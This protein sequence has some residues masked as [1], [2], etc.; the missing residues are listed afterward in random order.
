MCVSVCVCVCMWLC[1]HRRGL[2]QKHTCELPPPLMLPL[3]I[4]LEEPYGAMDFCGLASP[5]TLL[6]VGSCGYTCMLVV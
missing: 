4:K 2:G 3:G 1:V 6:G 5:E